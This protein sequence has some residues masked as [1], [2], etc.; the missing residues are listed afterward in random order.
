VTDLSFAIT[1]DY[2]CPFARNANEHVAAALQAGVPWDVR[3]V[4]FSLDQAHVAEGGTPVWDEPD[5]H[6]GLLANEVGIVVRDRMP[7]QFLAAHV[8][9]FAARHDQGLDTRKRE[10]LAQVLSGV[11]VDADAVFAEI[12]SGWPLKT[13]QEEHE[14]S[15]AQYQVFGVPTFILDD[16]AA[17]VRVMTRP[18]GDTAL[19]T[20]T[21]ERI[22]ELTSGWSDL[23][24]L[25]H[26]SIPR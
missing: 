7:E 25:K 6:P 24:E 12:D 26:T 14:T 11:G 20:R 18:E 22:T 1:W 15:A 3:W 16:Q 17:F 19:A 9:L 8:A 23:N 4:S 21:I 5:R 2:R 10:V 13:F